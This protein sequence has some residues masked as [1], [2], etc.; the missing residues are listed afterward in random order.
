[1]KQ[2]IDRLARERENFEHRLGR[3][4]K[5]M[6][7]KAAVKNGQIDEGTAARIESQLQV[8][9]SESRLSDYSDPPDVSTYAKGNSVCLR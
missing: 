3:A 9:R 8:S 5:T 4:R 6:I 2:T 7:F 1:M